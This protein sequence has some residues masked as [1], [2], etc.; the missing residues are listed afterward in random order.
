MADQFE[1][2]AAAATATLAEL[3]KAYQSAPEQ[4][5]RRAE[6]RAAVMGND[7]AGRVQADLEIARLR[8]ELNAPRPIRRTPFIRARGRGSATR[9]KELSITMA[10]RSRLATAS[11]L[12]LPRN[13]RSISAAALPMP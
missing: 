6:E 12:R 11:L 3:T 2:Q 5:L 9:S 1:A 4:Q 8:K 7:T 13:P 10:P